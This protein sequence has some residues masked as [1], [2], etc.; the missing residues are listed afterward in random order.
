MVY[1]SL[2]S[3]T[4]DTQSC[5]KFPKRDLSY[6]KLVTLWNHWRSTALDV[7]TRNCSANHN[8]LQRNS[9]QATSR[10]RPWISPEL[11]KEITQRYNKNRPLHEPLYKAL[12]YFNFPPILLRSISSPLLFRKEIHSLLLSSVCACSNHPILARNDRLSH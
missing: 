1:D 12:D 10:A 8:R 2:K 3:T 4:T 9:H 11:L 5:N 7:A 6:P